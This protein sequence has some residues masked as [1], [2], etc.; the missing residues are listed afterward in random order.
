MSC[1]LDGSA[2]SPPPASA[3]APAPPPPLRALGARES[4]TNSRGCSPARSH[5]AGWDTCACTHV[6][7]NH[8]KKKHGALCR[9]GLQ[10]LVSG[11]PGMLAGTSAPIFHESH[12]LPEVPPSRAPG[13]A[14]RLLIQLLM[15]QGWGATPAAAPCA[16]AQLQKPVRPHQAESHCLA[17]AQVGQPGAQQFVYV[18][19]TFQKQRSQRIRPSCHA[20]VQALLVRASASARASPALKA[21]HVPMICMHLPASPRTHHP[22]VAGLRLFQSAHT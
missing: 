12:P 11:R 2:V 7:G 16:G 19:S 15:R 17:P 1:T 18:R 14:H 8:V 5:Q 3:P 21:R 4:S 6:H 13:P 20:Q 22:A 10:D 9:A